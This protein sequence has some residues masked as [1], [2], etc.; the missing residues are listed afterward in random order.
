VFRTPPHPVAVT[1]MPIDAV[2]LVVSDLRRVY[3]SLPGVNGP[4]QSAERF[5]E[6]WCA[7]DGSAWHVRMRQRVHVL[8]EVRALRDVAAGE[9]RPPQEFD[10]PLVRDWV[11]G[12]VRDT[13]IVGDA[14]E[15]ADR[16]LQSGRP[17]VW[18]DHGARCMV[19]AARDTPSGACVNAVYTPPENRRRGYATAAVATLSRRLLEAG[20]T[21]CCLYT[22]VANPTSNAIYKRI[23]YEPI[24]EDVEIVFGSQNFP[25]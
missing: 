17:Y 19:A 14:S 13:G 23:G 5:A 18:D 9:L 7:L 8:T 20:K 2:A 15:L 10:A 6:Q 25:G 12:F 16:L 21:F 1:P 4:Q 11:A 24:R 22:D 3:P